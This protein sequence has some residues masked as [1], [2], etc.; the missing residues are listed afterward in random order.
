M[1]EEE[2]HLGFRIGFRAWNLH[3]YETY[4]GQTYELNPLHVGGAS[5]TPGVNI[6][7]C[8]S[9]RRGKSEIEG[10]PHGINDVDYDGCHCGFNAWNT[11]KGL[12]NYIGEDL[13]NLEA[14]RGQVAGIIAGAKK[15][16][17]HEDGFRSAEAQILALVGDGEAALKTAERY[18]VPCF[19][20]KNDLMAFMFDNFES[21]LTEKQKEEVFEVLLG[22]LQG[23]NELININLNKLTQSLS[24][25]VASYVTVA[26][27][28]LPRNMPM[29]Y[30]PDDMST[31]W[32]QAILENLNN[33]LQ[34]IP[35]EIIDSLKSSDIPR[36][37]NFE[38]FDISQSTWELVLNNLQVAQYYDVQ[39][40][41]GVSTY[42]DLHGNLMNTFQ[43]NTTLLLVVYSLDTA[44]IRR[45]IEQEIS[46]LKEYYKR[47]DL[48]SIITE[49][50]EYIKFQIN[51]F[52]E[53]FMN[54]KLK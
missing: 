54:G 25:K 44:A 39:I 11:L 2:T 1:T 21:H 10:V 52:E 50:D 41:D 4:N 43:T 34:D 22:E 32:E 18:G 40:K 9:M 46:S 51:C 28:Q 20:H 24:G 17:L 29:F 14:S 47:D 49:S 36:E 23:L 31:A 37:L 27:E 13:D 45:N 5:W 15:T 38:D 16:E 48:H 33:S 26:R 7:R 30:S 3:L 53:D 8:I 42:R 35:E 12:E 6:A 19:Q